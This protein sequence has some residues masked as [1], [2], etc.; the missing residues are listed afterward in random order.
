MAGA[1]VAASRAG[2]TADAL[3]APAR[4]RSLVDR[5][6][7]PGRQ[8]LRLRHAP[9]RDAEPGQVGPGGGVDPSGSAGSVIA[10]SLSEVEVQTEFVDDRLGDLVAEELLEVHPGEPGLL[11]G[12][13]DVAEVL[14]LL[15]VVGLLGVDERGGGGLV[16]DFLL[17]VLLLQVGGIQFDQHL[18][19]ADVLF[20][21]LVSLLDDLEDLGA[22]VADADLALDLLRFE[23]LDAAAF[24]HHDVERAAPGD[25]GEAAGVGLARRVRPKTASPDEAEHQHD[26]PLGPVPEPGSHREA[27]AACGR[28]PGW[29][30]AEGFNGVSCACGIDLLPLAVV[31]DVKDAHAVPEPQAGDGVPHQGLGPL[32]QRI[33]ESFWASTWSCACARPSSASR[34]CSSTRRS[35]VFTLIETDL[36]GALGLFESAPAVAHL[37][38]DFVLQLSERAFGLRLARSAPGGRRSVRPCGSRAGPRPG[39]RSSGND[40]VRARGNRW[41]CSGCCRWRPRR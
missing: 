31:F 12:G 32:V 21:D 3:G 18:V 10:G 5:P 11:L 27:R 17:G 36:V 4:R 1:L 39:P 2:A 40:R 16:L 19:G 38:L 26:L 6:V 41:S 33:D 35:A 20:G 15:D 22:L 14:V 25:E 28:A 34:S 13:L 37:E 29:S 23:G 30:G 24:E 8:T 9:A 7:G